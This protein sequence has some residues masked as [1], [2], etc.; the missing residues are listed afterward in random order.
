VDCL[1]S[2]NSL[3]FWVEV[4][5]A[6]TLTVLSLLFYYLGFALL[7]AYMLDLMFMSSLTDYY[8]SSVLQTMLVVNL[9]SC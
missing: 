3:I 4:V 7:P 8:I 5:S 1:F 6:S 2:P 9:L